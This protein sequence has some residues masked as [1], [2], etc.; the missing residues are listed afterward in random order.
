MKQI[1]HLHKM[2]LQHDETYRAK[3]LEIILK[4]IV[5]Y[6]DTFMYSEDQKEFEL[7]IYDKIKYLTDLQGHLIITWNAEY[8]KGE[9]VIIKK[10]W[11]LY[12]GEEEDNVT[13]RYSTEYCKKNPIGS[14]IKFSLT[15]RDKFKL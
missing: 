8:H 14:T 2:Q 9:E 12:G 10:L 7:P 4:A 13:S 15:N 11:D 3:R 1:E 5:L 6:D